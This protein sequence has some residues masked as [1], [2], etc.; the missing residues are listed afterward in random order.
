MIARP[1]GGAK[2]IGTATR[3]ARRSIRIALIAVILV[4]ATLTLSRIAAPYLVSTAIVRSAFASAMARWTGHDV[5]ISSIPAVSFW[6]TPEVT[7]MGVS[8][9]RQDGEERVALGQIDAIEARFSLMSAIKGRPDFKSFRLLRPKIRIERDAD[10]RLDWTDEGLLSEAV[11]AAKAAPDGSQSLAGAFDAEIG[12]VEVIDGEI[13]LIDNRDGHQV[14]LDQFDARLNWPRLS[15]PVSGTA[16][17]AL[18]GEAVTV[19]LATPSPL[20]LIKGGT[21]RVTAEASLTAGTGKF[22]GTVSLTEGLV[23]QSA[24]EL[25]ISDVPAIAK[26]AGLRLAGTENWRSFSLQTTVL[27]DPREWRFDTLAF[28]IDGSRGQG[29]AALRWLPDGRSRLSGTLAIDHLGLDRLLVALALPFDDAVAVRLP[30][31]L[32]WLDLDIRLSAPTASFQGLP[33]TDLGASLFGGAEDIALVIG[34]ARLFGGT[35]SARIGAKT[36]IASTSNLSLNL[37]NAEIG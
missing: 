7:L 32:R 1:E 28:Q 10:G 36:G 14:V 37:A 11:R 3:L 8:V 30:S 23:G 9:T 17:M 29:L 12:S 26:L 33:L 5:I 4:I 31:I 16:S 24:I 34:D 21:A 25:A 15:A 35:L 18:L 27:R 19:E 22:E 2:T 20:L 13:T 6:P